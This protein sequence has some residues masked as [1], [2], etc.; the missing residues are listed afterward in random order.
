MD[1]KNKI[2][3]PIGQEFEE[4]KQYYLQQ[5][6]SSIELLD[7]A[8]KHVA[9]TSGK[10][11]RPMLLL[12][13]AKSCGNI[14][15]STFAAASA[16]EL[17]HTASL[18]HDDVVDESN[19]RRGLPSLNTVYSNR[20]AILTGDY[21]LSSSLYNVAQTKNNEIIEGLAQLGRTLSAGEMLQLE[22]QRTGAYCEEKYLQVIANKTASLFASCGRFGAL[23]ANA[24]KES[25]YRF[26]RF[27]ELLGIC[28]QIKDD[29]FDYFNSDIG[30]PT[31][32]DIKEGKITLPALYALQ[33]SSDEKI[34]NI[35]RKLGNA[36]PLEDDEITT[37]IETAKS[38]GGIEYALARIEEYKSEAL[39]LLD[40]S[41][42]QDCREALTAYMQYV[43]TREK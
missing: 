40:D 37:L 15:A 20:I 7:N 33:N 13:S 41:L 18:L 34:K 2:V 38:C 25:V 24:D 23:S 29:I 12:L 4:F 42:P 43:I 22:L 3:Q 31:G 21:L 14:N 36:L 1:I 5:F 27:G 17:L 16:L 35:A 10:M 32:S 8:L 26:G 28:F 6:N 30:K 9:G 19:M 39:S 11:M